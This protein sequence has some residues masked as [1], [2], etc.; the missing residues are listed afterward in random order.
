MLEK[1]VPT[2]GVGEVGAGSNAGYI[3]PGTP[4]GEGT[5]VVLPEW[6]ISKGLFL[7]NDCNVLNK[8]SGLDML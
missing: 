1:E 7:V 5:E 6:E 4:Y 8:L 2:Q 3:N